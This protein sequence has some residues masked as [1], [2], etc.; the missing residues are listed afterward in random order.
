VFALRLTVR[1]SALKP[2]ACERFADIRDLLVGA[3][4]GAGTVLKPRAISVLVTLVFSELRVH[5]TWR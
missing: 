3:L 2:T 1:G 5:A 4:N